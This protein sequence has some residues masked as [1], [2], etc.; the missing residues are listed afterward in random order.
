ML[1]RARVV[2]DCYRK[3]F[4]CYFTVSQV[5]KTDIALLYPVIT[6]IPPPSSQSRPALYT[7]RFGGD[8]CC[9]GSKRLRRLA[10]RRRFYRTSLLIL[11][12]RPI[13]CRDKRASVPVRSDFCHF[14]K[15]NNALKCS[16]LPS[17]FAFDRKGTEKYRTRD[18]TC[19]V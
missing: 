10:R 7:P 1:H 18:V 9:T 16:V 6:L 19:A 14:Q 17:S 13:V 15:Q 5:A 4:P 3:L 2:S 8:I 11:L 12:S